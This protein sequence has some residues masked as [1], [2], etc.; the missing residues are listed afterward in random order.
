MD[1]NEM[2]VWFR[3]YAQQMGLQNVRAILPE[4][5][6]IVI[7]TSISD[8]VKELVRTNISLTSD[9]VVEDSTKL[10]QI[11]ALR[12]LSDNVDLDC[13]D[14]NLFERV[15]SPD[16]RFK[17]ADFLD[18]IDNLMYL[19]SLAI[20][21]KL[22]KSDVE[23]TGIYPVR[24]IEHMRLANT[25]RD[26]IMKP[27]VTSPIA[28]ISGGDLDL[29]LGSGPKG[30]NLVPNVLNVDFLKYPAKV[31]YQGNEDGTNVDCDLP[32]Y[33]HVDI[34]K[35]AVDLYRVSVQGSLYANQ[36]QQAQ[37]REVSR[38]NVRSGNE[39]YTQ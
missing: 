28:V 31:A 14:T 2:H 36:Q 25:L 39:G 24:I 34:L 7:N 35:H 16:W 29:Y 19:V 33:T 1:L 27:N 13:S 15:V 26:S 12:T 10:G 37:P 5:I 32:E 17:C 38:N 20:D 4:Q 18:K 22:N 23:A 21:Y 30:V 11:N 8:Y 3:Q 9:R 6:D